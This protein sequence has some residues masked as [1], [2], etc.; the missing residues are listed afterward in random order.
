M[1]TTGRRLL[2]IIG[3]LVMAGG[4]L[5]VGFWLG[6]SNVF[7]ADFFPARSRFF[8]L[9]G[10]GGLLSGVVSIAMWVLLIGLFVWGISGLLNR[11]SHVETVRPES[12]VPDSALDILQKRYARGE[13]T[14]AEFEDMRRDLNV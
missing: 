12:P 4:L 11:P 7:V 3:G 9:V 8:P 2:K 5:L 10:W 13:I 1:T 6:R 14:K